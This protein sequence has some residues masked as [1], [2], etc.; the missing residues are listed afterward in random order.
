MHEKKIN[1]LF[2]KLNLEKQF[3]KNTYALFAIWWILRLKQ[4]LSN[5]TIKDRKDKGILT[6]Y[7]INRYISE[8][9]NNILFFHNLLSRNNLDA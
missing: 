4:S 2:K 1:T 7:N 3:E 5:E 6:N 8:R 9:K